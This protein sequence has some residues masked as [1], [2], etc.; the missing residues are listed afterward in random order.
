MAI[1]IRDK[2]IYWQQ[3][4]ILVRF[5]LGGN[6][7]RKGK[8]GRFF[9]ANLHNCTPHPVGLHSL[10]AKTAKER[11]GREQQGNYAVVARAVD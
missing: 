4:A 8:Y 11:Q 1:R 2:P 5:N 10:D 3:R 6:L 9:N 7:A